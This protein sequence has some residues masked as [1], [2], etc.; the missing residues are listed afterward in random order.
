MSTLEVGL[1]VLLALGGVRS[2]WY[3]ASRPFQSA[4]LT[5]QLL[6]A[7]FRTARIASWFGFAGLFVLYGTEDRLSLAAQTR[8]LRWYLAIPVVLSGLQ[9]AAGLLLGRRRASEPPSE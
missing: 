1:A 2:L 9:F 5:D 7:I 6:Y 3:W 8:S 4:D